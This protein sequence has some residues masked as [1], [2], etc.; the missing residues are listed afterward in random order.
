MAT[1]GSSRPTILWLEDKP[2]DVDEYVKYARSL[3]LSVV[4][5]RVPRQV[6]NVLESGEGAA[7]PA[8]NV[9][10]PEE[11]KATDVVG[12]VVD[13]MLFGVTDLA[14]IGISNAD[15]ESGTS[16]GW[17][18]LSKYLRGGREAP[19]EI[20]VL[21]F[22]IKAQNVEEQAMVTRLNRTP[23][24]APVVFIRKIPD[25]RLRGNV[26]QDVRKWLEDRARY[27]RGDAVKA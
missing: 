20:P 15:T 18:F 3:G 5:C 21:I 10:A 16:A 6:A 9:S 12:I 14:D 27:G 2:R 25:D 22:S 24:Y 13:V 17:Q 19:Y 11:A 23:G 8:G 26:T 7:V 1:H 4:R